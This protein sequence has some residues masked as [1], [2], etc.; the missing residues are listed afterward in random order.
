MSNEYAAILDEKPANTKVSTAI[1]ELQLMCAG[2]SER[3]GDRGRCELERGYVVDYGQ[4]F[5]VTLIRSDNQYKLVLLR[6]YVPRGDFPT[7]LDTYSEE[8][9]ECK[10]LGRLKKELANFLRTQSV[11]NQIEEWFR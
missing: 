9:A 4:E 5:K 7:L 8:M 11:R 10:D 1:G 6:A 3:I 2:V